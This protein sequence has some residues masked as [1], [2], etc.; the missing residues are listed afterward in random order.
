M[1]DPW[2][3]RG[4]GEEI[5][6]YIRPINND[7]NRLTAVT[8]YVSSHLF[9]RTGVRLRNPAVLTA[10]DFQVSKPC[11]W[12]IFYQEEVK[13]HDTHKIHK[14]RHRTSTY[15]FRNHGT[16]INHGH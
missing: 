7:P 5:R 13:F 8:R 14:Y 10:M 6:P 1:F 2:E 16:L 9:G 3:K 15:A 12:L 11:N 4:C